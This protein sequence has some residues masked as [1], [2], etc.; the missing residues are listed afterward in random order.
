MRSTTVEVP[1]TGL[2]GS[3]VCGQLAVSKIFPVRTVRGALSFYRWEVAVPNRIVRRRRLDRDV[4]VDERRDVVVWR[5]VTTD[6]VDSMFGVATEALGRGR[7]RKT[8]YSK[9]QLESTRLESFDR[10]SL[11]ESHGDELLYLLRLRVAQSFHRGE[12][13]GAELGAERPSRRVE[14][15][16]PRMELGRLLVV[17]SFSSR[18]FSAWFNAL[19]EQDTSENR[20]AP[21][22]TLYTALTRLRSLFPF[23]QRA[24]ASRSFPLATLQRRLETVRWKVQN[25]RDPSTREAHTRFS[26]TTPLTRQGTPRRI[27]LNSLPLSLSQ[28]FLSAS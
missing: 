22:A 3:K 14:D 5:P 4:T 17:S 1:R 6:P 23:L 9:T 25:S 11:L 15:R 7:I 8:V 2:V 10:L 16:G 28:S 27:S 20:S 18:P 19:E 26:I 12:A 24:P 21:S 13:E